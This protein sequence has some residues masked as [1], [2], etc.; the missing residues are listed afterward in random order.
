MAFVCALAGLGVDKRQAGWMGVESFPPLLSG[1]LKTSRFMIVRKTIETSDRMRDRYYI[2]E[3][4][5][6]INRFIIKGTHGPV[7]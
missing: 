1:L 2:D 4:G 7:Q 3:L 6:I 5:V